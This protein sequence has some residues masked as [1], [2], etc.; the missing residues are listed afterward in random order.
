[1]KYQVTVEKH[2][3]AAH[4]LREYKGRC[5]RLHGHN[6]KVQLTICG[7]TLNKTGMLV[8]FTE[9]REVLGNILAVLDHRYINE[10]A[11][12]DRINPTAENIAAF[13]FKESDKVYKKRGV[14][15]DMVRVW[16][17]EASFATVIR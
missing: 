17:S 15:T 16:E 11:P 10:V 5:E 4:A 13:V 8:D 14:R 3:A 2:F 6:W 9:L 12:F 1:M 7:R